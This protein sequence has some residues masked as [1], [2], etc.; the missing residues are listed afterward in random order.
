VITPRRIQSQVRRFRGGGDS[1]GRLDI[2]QSG[3]VGGS[4]HGGRVSAG[5]GT[6]VG[7][8]VVGGNGGGGW[9]NGGCGALGGA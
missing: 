9:P 8:G 7:G 3:A 2:R 5:G 4:S 6:N 1:G